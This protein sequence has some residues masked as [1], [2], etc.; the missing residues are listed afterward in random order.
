MPN[1]P[2]KGFIV[3]ACGV[4]VS[5]EQFPLN[6]TGAIRCNSVVP[7]D[8]SF[9]TAFLV[10]LEQSICEAEI[11]FF[12][13]NDGPRHNLESV[14]GCWNVGLTTAVHF[15]FAIGHVDCGVSPRVHGCNGR[16]SIEDFAVPSSLLNHSA[17]P[18][19]T[20]QKSVGFV[21]GFVKAFGK[22]SPC[23]G[24]LCVLA[25]PPSTTQTLFLKVISI[26]FAGK[27]EKAL[28]AFNKQ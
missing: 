26:L 14:G 21:R 5:R 12:H 20:I 10:V 19:Q 24:C 2:I 11:S 23:K 27:R 17:S 22:E 9:I 6:K 3:Y 28:R 25:R 15:V 8:I 18:L 1:F 16:E 7:I 13:E 4:S